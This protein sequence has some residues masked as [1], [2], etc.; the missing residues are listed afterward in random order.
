M[1]QATKHTQ[2]SVVFMG[3]PA[4][5]LPTLE[6]LATHP[7]VS[8]TGVFT[9]PPQP[10]GRGHH[11]QKSVIHTRAE[12]LG[13]TVF[14]PTRLKDEALR[15]LE[16][17]APTLIVVAAYGL[18]LPKSVLQIPPLGCVNIHA[19]LLPR[20]RGAAPVHRS[21]LAGDAE[22]GATLMRIDEGMDTGAMLAKRTCLI[23][24]ETTGLSLTQAVAELGGELIKSHLSALLRGELSETPQPDA[25]AIQAPRLTNAEMELD[26][27]KD[28]AFLER[29]IR[30]FY[31][32]AF[33]EHTA[34]PGQPARRFRILKAT[35]A[36]EKTQVQAPGTLVDE[37]LTIACGKG[38]LQPQLI[39]PE[40]KKPLKRDAFL[41]GYG[42][43]FKAGTQLM[44]QT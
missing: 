38:L 26:W 33:F 37:A 31:P 7:L 20:W 29:A 22:T 32:K 27:T 39:A 4:F 2:P 10:K 12:A 43:L 44:P 1:N 25:G 19:S 36:P 13:L 18:L 15:Q 6:A 40:G 9:K 30:T 24:P 42:H 34:G 28:A 35:V 21:L 11:K 23:T 16:Q 8:L 14:T 3:T 17:L 41:N 5:A